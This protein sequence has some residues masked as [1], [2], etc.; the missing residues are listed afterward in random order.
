MTGATKIHIMTL[1]LS[2]G[3]DSR[4]LFWIGTSVVKKLELSISLRAMPSVVLDHLR[5]YK[6]EGEKQAK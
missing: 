3:T 5:R 6:V 2:S 4:P 1:P